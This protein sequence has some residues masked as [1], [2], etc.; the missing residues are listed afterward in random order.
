MWDLWEAM[1]R[2]DLQQA[3]EILE[4]TFVFMRAQTDR[5][6]KNIK[7]LGA[8]LLY[9]ERDVGKALLSALMRFSMDLSLSLAEI[10][11]VKPV[12]ENC[13]KR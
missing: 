11:L 10:A 9:R 13:S 6:R 5:A 12:D 3:N 7:G 4:P 1:R 8:Y 2:C